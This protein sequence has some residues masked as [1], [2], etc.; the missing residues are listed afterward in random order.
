MLSSSRRE[1]VRVLRLGNAFVTSA[2]A[3]RTPR[4]HIPT[5]TDR[6]T[7]SLRP[8]QSP[9]GPSLPPQRGCARCS[10]LG[11]VSC[12]LGQPTPVSLPTPCPAALPQVPLPF[13][14]LMNTHL[15]PNHTGRAPPP[16][17]M[18]VGG[19]CLLVVAKQMLRWPC[20]D[21]SALY[22]AV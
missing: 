18:E 16:V 7:H 6:H 20:A 21:C 11:A 9:C 2:H 1:S 5:C 15:L 17:V 12:A 8:L 10:K 13:H 3:Y 19:W 22:A 4:M 14:F